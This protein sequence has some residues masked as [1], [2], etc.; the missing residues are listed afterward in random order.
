LRFDQIHHVNAVTL[1]KVLPHAPQSLG[2]L[3]DVDARA[4]RYAQQCVTSHSAKH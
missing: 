1:D 2:D 3:L 4:R